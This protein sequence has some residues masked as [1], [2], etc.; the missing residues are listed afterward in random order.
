M[1]NHLTK[2]VTAIVSSAVSHKFILGTDFID[3]LVY[4]KNDR[5]VVLNGIKIQRFNPNTKPILLRLKQEIVL[6]PW[7][8]DLELNFANLLFE[9][10]DTESILIERPS[11][12]ASR[13][14]KFYVCE[15]VHDNCKTI[16]VNV[17]NMSPTEI[18][19]R[20][21]TIVCQISPSDTVSNK[22]F[23]LSECK[24]KETERINL[25]EFQKS[26]QRKFFSA[27]N[28]LNIDLSNLNENQK[29]DLQK[30]IKQYQLAFAANENDLG[31][32]AYWRFSVPFFDEKA[33]C[34]QAPRPI[35]PGLVEKV[36]DEFNK[37]T[38]NDLVEEAYSPV[39]IPVLIVR[40][41]NGSILLALDARKLNSICV[42]IGF[43]CRICQ[44]IFIEL[45]LFCPTPQN[46]L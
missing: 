36:R 34:Y 31:R 25:N 44:I 39:N 46:P 7:Q 42:K 29:L 28:T 43:L 19:L 6:S 27:S 5:C 23:S 24:D 12:D 38:E 9:S 13:Y 21:G 10:T 35:P 41:P 2:S 15:V 14:H 26:R 37:W 45:G 8:A 4:N 20:K 30:I 11:R 22:I 1:N 3:N 33:E 32:I 17:S 18:K 40:K 16:N